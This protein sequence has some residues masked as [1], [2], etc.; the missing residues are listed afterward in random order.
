MYVAVVGALAA[1]VTGG[2]LINQ[3]WQDAANL[4]QVQAAKQASDAALAK[5]KADTDAAL[6]SKTDSDS[7]LTEANGKIDDLTK[8]LADAKQAATDAQTAVQ[9]ATDNA[10]AAQDKYDKIMATLGSD[11]PDSL[12]ADKAK[13]ESDLAAAESEKKIMEDQLADAQKQI[14]D[15]NDEIN[16][17]KTGTQPPGISGKVTFVNRAWNFVVLNV[18]LANG[19]VPNG[20]L[21]VYR[22]RDF[23]GKV[24]VTSAE[25]NSAVADILPD[26]KGDI[27]VG[28]YVLN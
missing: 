26:I 10:K 7:K 6:A 15:A 24:K 2:L 9:T 19:V 17:A 18:G 5:A 13:A 25:S 21:I 3:R 27:Q 4:K 11:T 16:R 20:E 28:D 14:A 23:L 12:K 22:G 8:Q 1:A